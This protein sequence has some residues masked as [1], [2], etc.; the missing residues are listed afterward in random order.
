WS[1]S[2]GEAR[3]ALRQLEDG[4]TIAASHTELGERFLHPDGSPEP[5]FTENETNTE[6]FGIAANRTPYVKDA[7]HACVLH[8]R[9]DAVNPAKTGTKA[10]A[11]YQF[12]VEPGA[13]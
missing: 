5:L 10:A 7:F 12:T 2:E 4:R 6:R 11:H 9:R 13:S 3:P 1:W 8:G